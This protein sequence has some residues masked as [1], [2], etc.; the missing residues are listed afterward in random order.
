[1]ETSKNKSPDQ[2][3][4]VAIIIT[5][6][7]EHHNKNLTAKGYKV[8][9]LARDVDGLKIDNCD[10]SYNYRQHLNSTQEK[11]DISDW[12]SYH[13]NENDEWLTIWSSH[14]FERTAT[15]SLFQIVRLPV[16]KM[17]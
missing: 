12:L 11:E 3:F 14:V 16:V 1:M 17:H 6:R 8:A 5:K 2:F 15:I 9:I 10:F 13:H 7:K 4:G